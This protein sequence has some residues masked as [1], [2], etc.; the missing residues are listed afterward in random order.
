MFIMLHHN[1][2]ELLV[3]SPSKLLKLTRWGHHLIYQA[4][5]NCLNLEYTQKICSK[6]SC[7][8]YNFYVQHR[9][10]L[11]NFISIYSLSSY[12]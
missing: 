3:N 4:L 11:N 2:K 7:I 9:G 5:G 1:S 10:G 8:L 6:R 12:G